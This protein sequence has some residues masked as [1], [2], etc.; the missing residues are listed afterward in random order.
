MEVMRPHRVG[1]VYAKQLAWIGRT[2]EVAKCVVERCGST[3]VGRH[4]QLL[5]KDSKAVLD[6]G[7]HKR[8]LGNLGVWGASQAELI[9][10]MQG[11]KPGS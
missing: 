9:S 11:I 8:R 3:A 7:T 5:Y 10:N 2:K 4:L 1:T 6:S